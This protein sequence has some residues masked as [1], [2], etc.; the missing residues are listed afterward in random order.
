MTE[1][2]GNLHLTPNEGFEIAEI[3]KN[4]T[5]IAGTSKVK[6]FEMVF[7]D[8]ADG[9]IIFVETNP[10]A[11]KVFTFVGDGDHVYLFTTHNYSYYRKENQTDGAW[12]ITIPTYN[13]TIN[14]NANEG[15]GIESV[16][17]DGNTL[18]PQ[19]PS[20]I[21]IYS[22]TYFVSKTFTINTFSYAEKRD[23]TATI[24]VDGD[25]S[26]VKITRK[27]DVTV[28][29]EELDDFKFSADELPLTLK[30]NNYSKSLYKVTV[31]G[32]EASRDGSDWKINELNDGD[33]IKIEVD[34]PQVDVPFTATFTQEGTEGVIS[35]LRV[36]GPEIAR[37]VWS[38]AGYTVP[39]GAQIY[40]TFDTQSY[41]IKSIKINGEPMDLSSSY[42][43]YNGNVTDASGF[44]IE[45]DAEAY[46]PFNVK[47]SCR[48]W[49]HLIVKANYSNQ[50][51]LTGA[52][53]TV[54][55]PR[56]WD[57]VEI[58]PAEGYDLVE[59]W[60]GETQ[61]SNSF[62]LS[63]L[64][65]VD[66]VIEVEVVLEEYLRDKQMV[67]FVEEGIWNYKQITLAQTSN[68]QRKTINLETGYN[69]INFNKNDL[70]LS[71]SL[72]GSD[73]SISPKVYLDGEL[74]TNSYGNYPATSDME[75]GSVLKLFMNEPESHSV[76][77]SIE[78]SAEALVHADYVTEMSASTFDVHHGTH[79]VISAA[80][81]EA[82]PA[83]YSA[84]P[85]ASQVP[86][87]VT[88]GGASVEPDESGRVIIPVTGDTEIAVK[89][90]IGTGVAEIGA[91]AD[92]KVN[93]FNLQGIKVLDKAAD[94]EINHLPAGMYIVNG[95]KVIIK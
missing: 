31:N 45:I 91:A 68:Y 41:D 55:I 43:Y 72:Y 71:M 89:K 86:F 64:T 94:S 1:D 22:G 66:G 84:A 50:I 32:V 5:A 33:V 2:S 24:E 82:A 8:Y 13:T 77:L 29:Q 7:S 80:P 38:A 18:L 17:V 46:Q 28:K 57:R 88:A 74:I 16:E 52:E 49:E 35:S 67:V 92:G 23:K 93:V 44:T 34:F 87:V 73:Y 11:Q 69:F 51:E 65:A 14:I 63:S 36:D 75:D 81:Q 27:G 39:L 76:T 15:Y 79:I 53:T 85:R 83:S 95:K 9:D 25:K 10:V 19:T 58:S 26:A 6:S 78:E 30:H 21:S 60:N 20:Y 56:G 37:S 40:M 70:P 12:Q 61:L 62:Y 90:G 4:G 59:I 54:E 42:L 48:E 47:F 3:R